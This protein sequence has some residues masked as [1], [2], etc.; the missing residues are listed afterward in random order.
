MFSYVLPVLLLRPS[1]GPEAF[2]CCPWV[3]TSVSSKHGIL[4]KHIQSKLLVMISID[5]YLHVMPLPQVILGEEVTAS[6][7]T[8]FDITKQICDAVQARAGQG[9]IIRTSLCNV[10]S[11]DVF[12]L[13]TNLNDIPFICSRQ[14]SW[15]HPNSWRDRREY[16]WTLCFVEGSYL[17]R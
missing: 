14:K 2:T 13:L 10:G 6:K 15:S 8:I 4:F 11:S 16:S 9:L 5:S 12:C 7:L 1:H 3:Y 17:K